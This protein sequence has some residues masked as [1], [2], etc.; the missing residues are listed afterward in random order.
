MLRI[1][2]NILFLLLLGL[3]AVLAS[4]HEARSSN[5]DLSDFIVDTQDD[6]LVVR[7]SIEMD[8]LTKIESLLDNGSEIALIYQVKVFKKYSFFP[9]YLLVSREVEVEFEKDLIS[10]NYDIFYPDHT[11]KTDTLELEDFNNL[12]NDVTVSLLPMENFE[13]QQ[14]YIA[15]FQARVISK[16]IPTWIKRTLFFWSWDLDKSIQYEMEFSL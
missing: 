11:K 1:K 8:D 13:L 4:V 9:N 5:L 15:R 3:L 7:F 2:H 6:H 10:G 14:D 12:F 16:N